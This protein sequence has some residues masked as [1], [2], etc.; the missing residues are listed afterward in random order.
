LTEKADIVALP[1]FSAEFKAV[2]SWGLI[3]LK[4]TSI[5]YLKDVN[6][7]ESRQLVVS[8]IAEQLAHFVIIINNSCSSIYFNIFITHTTTFCF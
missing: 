5:L 8:T 6:S 4:E 1:E 7:L 2:E 3:Q